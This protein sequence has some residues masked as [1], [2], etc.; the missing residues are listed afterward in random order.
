VIRHS[1]DRGA[2]FLDTADMHGTGKNER[3]V[4]RAITDRRDDVFLLP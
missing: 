4:G 1:I 3:L 2:T